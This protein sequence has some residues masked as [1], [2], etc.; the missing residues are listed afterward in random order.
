MKPIAHTHRLTSL[1]IILSAVAGFSACAS[2]DT[3]SRQSRITMGMLKMVNFKAATLKRVLAGKPFIDSASVQ[4]APKP[5]FARK[6]KVIVTNIDGSPV[7]TISSRTGSSKKIVLYL[8]GGAYSVSFVPDHWKLFE[9]LVEQTGCTIVA[10]GY[11]LP[12]SSTWVESWAMVAK[13]Y[14]ELTQAGSSPEIILMGDSAGGGFALAF[15]QMLSQGNLPQPE[16]LILLSPWLDI[17]MAN[18]AIPAMMGSD[19]FLSIEALR[20][21]GKRWAGSTDPA[22]W[23]LSPIHGSFD[24]L[25]PITV[26]TGTADILNP[27]AKKLGELCAAREIPLDYREYQ[28][29]MHVWMLFDFPESLQARSEITG[30]IR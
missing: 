7:Y 8:H 15:S 27:D 10:P 24:N 30:L 9:Y 25:P 2:A 18:P 5:A 29:M 11:P 19:P 22:D 21:S 17:A 26:F 14:D 28:G 6:H 1:V 3:T 12:P 13:L 4:P 20:L 16:K 23:H